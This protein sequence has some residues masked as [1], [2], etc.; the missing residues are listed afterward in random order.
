MRIREAPSKYWPDILSLRRTVTVGARNRSRAFL[1]P[2]GV[3]KSALLNEYAQL[4]LSLAC[5]AGHTSTG[6]VVLNSDQKKLKKYETVFIVRPNLDDDS[7]DRTITAVED[8][9]KQNGG[10]VISTDKKGRRRLAYE[11]KKMRDGFYVLIKFDALPAAVA[12]L[13]R[14]MSLSEDIIRCL[15]VALEGAAVETTL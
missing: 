11:V 12:G 4:C 8:F 7:V 15:V 6:D 14:M 5:L 2:E 1:G 3:L 10:V 13:K 9:I